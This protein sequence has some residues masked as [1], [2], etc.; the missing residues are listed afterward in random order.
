MEE[1]LTLHQVE[2]K[3]VQ[4]PAKNIGTDLVVE[5]LESGMA[6]IVAVTLPSENRNALEQHP[7]SNGHGGGP[8]DDRVA[9]EVDLG[10]VLAPEVDT[11]AEDGPRLRARVPSVGVGQASVGGP[12]DLVEFPELAKEARLTVVDLLNA[13]HKLRVLVV[14]DIPQAVGKGAATSTGDLLLLGSPV[15]ELD[16]VG[17][18]DTA[19]HDVDKAELGLN[20]ADTLLGDGTVRSLLDNLN[21]EVVVGITLKTLIAISRDLVLPVSLGDRGSDI[22]GVEAAVG[23][24]MEEAEDAAMLDVLG[25]RKGVPGR[26][27]VDGLA[28]NAK[29]LSLVLE[30]PDVVVVL[31]RVESDL[32]L[33]AARGV[34]EGVG[35]E[36]ATSGVDMTNANAAAHDDIGRDILHALAVKSGLKFGA[37][38]TITVTG[39]LENGEVNGEHGHVEG[40]GDDNE[41]EDTGHEVLGPKALRGVSRS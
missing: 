14:L 11:A 31:V 7:D 27:T 40:D 19:S 8:P 13:V 2:G 5:T 30:Q 29:G 41:G 1:E 39:V 37:H 25:L 22:V 26:G 4:G 35:V 17:E 38:E 3:V 28:I 6:V 20:D 21:A 32:L 16:L 9:N 10:V 24:A 33:L 12:H 15:R 34:H 36:V 23:G 18:E